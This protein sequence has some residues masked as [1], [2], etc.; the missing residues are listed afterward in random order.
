MSLG[1][2]EDPFNSGGSFQITVTDDLGRPVDRAFVEGGA[3]HTQFLEQTNIEGRA[4][5][6]KSALG[7]QAF[8]F[9]TDYLTL[10]VK[11]LASKTYTLRE[12]SKRLDLIGDVSGKAVRFRATELITLERDGSFHLYSFNDQSINEQYNQMLVDSTIVVKETKLKGDTLF[13]TT[14]NSGVYV[15]SITNPAR[16]E[17]LFH[18][19]SKD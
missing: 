8:I 19:D 1:C 4:V 15:F 3:D 10:Q 14:L 16:P 9:K 12:T 5:I 2:G 18:L 7:G 6:P 17:F 13:F 11:E